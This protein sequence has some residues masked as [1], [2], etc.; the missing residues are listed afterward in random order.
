MSEP[1]PLSKFNYCN[2][3]AYFCNVLITYLIGAAGV[4]GLPDNAVLSK[5]YQ[6]IV[7]PIGWAFSIWGP[8]FI[9]QAVFV[10]MQML[11]QYRASDFVSKGVAY[12]YGFV[13]FFQC[14]W[15]IAF[16]SEV[17]W[18]SVVFMFSILI[19]LALLVR[20]LNTNVVLDTD[21]TPGQFFLY[22]F[23]FVLHCGWIVAA[24][25]VNFSVA[26]VAYDD[27]FPNNT[28]LQ[29]QICIAVLSFITLSLVTAYSI[30]IMESKGTGL[31]LAGVQAWALGGVSAQLSSPMDETDALFND[32][33]LGGL[34]L[35]AQTLSILFWIAVALGLVRVI[36]LR[37]GV[38]EENK[39]GDLLVQMG[40]SE[41]V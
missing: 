6:T 24:S 9:S 22:K 37:A 21:I 19:S 7:T 40:G 18:L 25:A 17:M 20:S 23:P 13:C 30:F 3:A 10:V 38:I 11:P 41:K 8:I 33:V 36:L 16:S 27:N 35:T 4:G 14:C 32:Q 12:W 15:T 29:L 39:K 31:V 1:A 2:A 34:Q 5:K 28:N 26:V